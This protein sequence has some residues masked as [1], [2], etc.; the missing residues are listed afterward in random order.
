MPTFKPRSHF[1]VLCTE[2]VLPLS[3]RLATARRGIVDS[4]PTT[5]PSIARRLMIAVPPYYYPVHMIENLKSVRTFD[6]D[7]NIFL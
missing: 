3:R 2:E 5:H 4:V 1:T 7:C 6:E